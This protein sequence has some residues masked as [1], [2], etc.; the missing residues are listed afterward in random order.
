MKR[1]ELASKIWRT[2]VFSGAMLGAPLAAADSPPVELV[3]AADDKLQTELAELDK[4]LAT[5]T[6]AAKTSK[7]SAASRASLDALQRERALLVERIKVAATERELNDLDAKLKA[8]LTGVAAAKTDAER[9]VAKQRLEAIQK[10]RAVVVERIS[11]SL[12]L[13]D[14]ARLERELTNFD[15]KVNEAVDAVVAAQHDADRQA[16]KARLV[17]LQRTKSELEAKLAAVKAR[18]TAAKRPRAPE[19]DRPIGRGFILS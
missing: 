17:A 3:V 11:A 9:G 6:A 16:A 7:D 18:A 14:V 19:Q 8:A 10:A 1:G 12:V 2:V 4:K 15:A 13:R 5:A